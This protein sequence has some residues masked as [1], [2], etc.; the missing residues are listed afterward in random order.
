MTYMLNPLPARTALIAYQMAWADARRPDVDAYLARIHAD[1]RD[2]FCA[3][4]GDWLA[5]APT[6][7]YSP[8]Q[9][10]EIRADPILRAALAAAEEAR[11]AR[12]SDGR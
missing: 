3:A 11:N 12:R 9:L 4:V 2:A 5:V 10:A 1:E 8:V 7:D 6:P